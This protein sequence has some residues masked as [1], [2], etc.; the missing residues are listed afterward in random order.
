MNEINY[1]KKLLELGDEEGALKELNSYL[2]EN[3][4]NTEAWFIL[5]NTLDNPEEIKDC[6]R[7]IIRVDPNNRLAQDNLKHLVDASNK[8]EDSELPDK[9]K[10]FPVVKIIW[11]TGILCVVLG[12]IYL[13]IK[14][15]AKNISS[16]TSP[17]PTDTASLYTKSAESYIPDLED[18]PNCYIAIGEDSFGSIVGD[19][20]Q[21]EIGSYALR[22]YVNPE[23]ITSE[24]EIIGVVYMVW[25]FDNIIEVDKSYQ[26]YIA[27][28]AKPVDNVGIPVDRSAVKI[29][30]KNS[31]NGADCFFVHTKNNVLFSTK[32][33]V[34]IA[35]E[36]DFDEIIMDCQNIY[37]RTVL[38]KLNE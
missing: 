28:G 5:A 2:K 12:I 38:D 29:E 11:A 24:N 10:G 21:S 8:V 37:S 3:P 1:I 17:I 4:K 35:N 18:L 13:L 36:T 20:N 22:G 27:E 16:S 19:T 33:R 31:D 14:P 30:R 26:D 9:R 25:V 6:Y 7:Q 23:K 34:A 15:N 32:C